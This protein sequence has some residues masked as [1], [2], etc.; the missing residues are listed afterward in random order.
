M[1]DKYKI[2]AVIVGM[3][4]LASFQTLAEP[5]LEKPQYFDHYGR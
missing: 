5:T 4:A 3:L 1:W 2:Y